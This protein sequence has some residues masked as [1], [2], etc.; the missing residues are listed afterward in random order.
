MKLRLDIEAL[1]ALSIILVIGYHYFPAL[2][3]G[4]YVGVDAFFVIS[5]YLVTHTLLDLTKQGLPWRAVLLEFWARRVRRLL[6]HALAVL[7]FC[8]LFGIA[9]MS[10]VSRKKL[11]SDIFWSAGFAVNWL[12][13]LRA[14]NY[15]QWD[16]RAHGLILNFWS[17]A[18]EEQFYAIWPLVLV[19]LVAIGAGPRRMVGVVVGLAL[20]SLTYCVWLT[21]GNQSFAFFSSPAR[22]WELLA[23][24]MLSLTPSTTVEKGTPRWASGVLIALGF[25]L[26]SAAGVTFSDETVHPGLLTLLPVLGSALVL[27]AGRRG[28]STLQTR[29]RALAP[30]QYLG[31]RSY[32]IYL[33]HWPVLEMW[34]LLFGS[35]T[36]WY[37]MTCLLVSCIVAEGGYR[38]LE[39]PMRHRWTKHWSN[40]RTLTIMLTASCAVMMSGLSLREISVGSVREHFSLNSEAVS[41]GLKLP[42]LESTQQDLPATYS[43]GCH[44]D[45]ESIRSESCEFGDTRSR[46]R[47][48]LFGDSH[49][50]QWFP[51]LE[52]VAKSHG[53]KLIAWTKS[54]CP[55][56]DISVRNQVGRGVFT[57][58]D[59]W[60]EDVLQRLLR[61]PPKMVVVSNIIL[62][63]MYLVDR[64]T[65]RSLKGAEALDW[66]R[67]GLVRTIRRLQTAGISVVVIRDNPKPRPDVLDCIYSAA[68][69]DICAQKLAAATASPALDVEAAKA[70][71]AEL[72]DLS[73]QICPGDICPTVFNGPQ[74]RSIYRDSNHLTASF[75]STLTPFFEQHW[76]APMATQIPPSMATSKSPT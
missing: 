14:T 47:V 1:R 10:V 38:F 40:R 60:R 7:A 39:T 37:A 49:A 63:P 18:V 69:P 16:D 61:D 50:A 70:T 46:T 75:V 35:I 33:W 64:D 57:Q 25:A 20:T 59:E 34:R 11:G 26:V 29:T 22:G 45:L 43:L 54:N 8:G 36:N 12:Y 44:L 51:A 6:P 23:G 41:T 24:A 65:G 19:G 28:S 4:G 55:S 3:P 72:W 73:N 30:V 17:L 2:L 15:L 67:Q 71:G 5:G 53:V 21:E 42:S 27:L 62:E 9:T 13:A 52:S 32:A 76:Q 31:S 68:T 48:V 58:C 74:W 56:A 66:W